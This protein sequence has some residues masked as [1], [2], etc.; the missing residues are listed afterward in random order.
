MTHGF[1]NRPN[2]SNDTA[3]QMAGEL[4]GGR[5]MGRSESPP[6]ARVKGVGRQQ[7][8]IIIKGIIQLIG[9]ILQ[10]FSFVSSNRILPFIYTVSGMF[11]ELLNVIQSVGIC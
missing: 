10:S 8:E 9:L 5:H 1:V 2:R 7:Q 6:Q 4:A 11:V 3:G